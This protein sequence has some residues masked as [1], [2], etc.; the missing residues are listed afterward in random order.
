L[1]GTGNPWTVGI[2]ASAGAD[3][4]DGL[5]WCRTVVDHETDRLNHFQHFDLFTDQTRFADLAIA[6]Q[7]LD[8][9]GVDFAGKVAFHNID[10]FKRFNVK[11]REMAK[12][13][14]LESF[15]TSR[16]GKAATEMLLRL[17][18]EVFKT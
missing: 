9:P 8:D 16:L 11:L 1:L 5:E 6:S 13:D 3:C 2:L 10:Y 14:R 7:A 4:F 18:P 17:N 15:V 12:E